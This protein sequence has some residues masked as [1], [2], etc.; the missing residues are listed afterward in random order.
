METQRRVGGFRSIEKADE[1][2]RLLL[3][4]G[5]SKEN[6]MVVCPSK[7]QSHF[8][9]KA[10]KADTPTPDSMGALAA[11]GV[12]GASLGGLALAA[13]V[14]TGGAAGPAAAVLIGGGALAGG[15]SNLIAAKGY[16]EEADDYYKK[17]VNNGWIVVGVEIADAQA[18]PSI[19]DAERILSQ[20][21]AAD[22][23]PT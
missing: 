15:I 19:T 3:A 20:S 12:A 18:V 9:V 23:T 5:F 1:V 11:G 2:I 7:Y 6:L 8:Q 21:G 10:P 22:V 4:A 17:A 13:T 14:L 16:A